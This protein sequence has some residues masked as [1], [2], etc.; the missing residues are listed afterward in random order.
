MHI[1][2]KAFFHLAGKVAPESAVFGQHENNGVD[3]IL[4]FCTLSC[5]SLIARSKDCY[6]RPWRIISP[7]CF[8]SY[9]EVT[10]FSCF[11]R[12]SGLL[13]D[14][15]IWARKICLF[16]RRQGLGDFCPHSRR[17]RSQI[18]YVVEMEPHCQKDDV[19]AS[20]H[21][22]HFSTFVRRF[23]KFWYFLMHFDHNFD[24]KA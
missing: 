4:N 20:S 23:P 13:G 17:K 2:L 8:A 3:V 24:E 9:S 6:F 12:N 18:W 21:N 5:R 10:Y 14:F 16:A 1:W 11:M 15:R 22:L 19:L 7:W